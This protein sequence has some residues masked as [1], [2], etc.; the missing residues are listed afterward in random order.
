MT[1]RHF[2]LIAIGGG[3]AGLVSAAGGAALGLETALI[4]KNALG[5]DCLWTGCVPSKALIAAARR[6][7]QMNHAHELGLARRHP[8]QSFR[9]VME[10]MKQRRARI[11]VHDDPDRFRKMGVAVEFGEAH[12]TGPRTVEV[13][14]AELSARRI[15]VATGAGPAIPP[16]PGLEETGFLTYESVF[17]ETELPGRLAVLGAGPIGLELAQAFARLGSE[18]TVLEMLP[19][20]LPNEDETAS[21]ALLQYLE[22]E[23]IRVHTGTRVTAVTRKGVNADRTRPVELSA[24]GP[25][26]PVTIKVDGILVATG[27]KANTEGLGLE[28]IGV[29]TRN[30]AVEVNDYL[31]AS[32]R[33]IW[34]AGD[35]TGGLQFTHVADYQAKLVLRNAVFPFKSKANYAA[36]PRVTFTDPE[37]AR[38]GLTETEAREKVRN[39]NV[40][41]YEFADLDRAIADGNTK[42]FV[43]VV[44]DAKG[45]ILGATVVSSG[46]GE[47]IMPFVLAVKHGIKLPALSQTVFPYPTMAEGVKRAADEYYREKLSG[48][49]GRWLRII[50]SLL[51]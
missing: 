20:I 25:G 13:N 30:G 16:I 3:T 28:E 36:V 43:K 12:L 49:T 38:V 1:G 39:V 35:V 17:D 24:E 14:G 4:E 11:A 33:G 31:Q 23:G 8:E 5:G 50:V 41:E 34:A 27:R 42:G 40:F 48:R 7:H 2:D 47:L 18:V 21:H 37:V 45:R 32:R 22:E 9:E 46:G 44:A 15:V 10:S 51:K 19:R 29:R 6:A 26:G